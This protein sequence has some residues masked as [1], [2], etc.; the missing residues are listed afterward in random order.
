V[1]NRPEAP[2]SNSNLGERISI[3]FRIYGDDEHPFSEVTGVLLRVEEGAEPGRR[4]HVLRRSGE[5]VEVAEKDVVKLKRIPA[6]TGPVRSP[7]A[8]G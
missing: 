1:A 3:L 8:W 5:V 4:L 7:E 6:G 2:L